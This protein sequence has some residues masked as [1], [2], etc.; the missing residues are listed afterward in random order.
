MSL[1]RGFI[2]AETKAHRSIEG[3][4]F[5]VYLEASTIYIPRELL[6]D[7]GKPASVR[8]GYRELAPTHRNGKPGAVEIAIARSENDSRPSRR[9]SYRENGSGMVYAARSLTRRLAERGLGPTVAVR[10][11]RTERGAIIGLPVENGD[12]A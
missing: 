7:L 4:E 1:P 6:A 8:V 12:R 5:S 10:V 2:D 9:V 11:E 3:S